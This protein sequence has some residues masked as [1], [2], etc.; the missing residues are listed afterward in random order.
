MPQQ[1]TGGVAP[2]AA[3]VEISGVDGNEGTLGRRGVSSCSQRSADRRGLDPSPL[4]QPRSSSATSR[5]KSMLGR[6]RRWRGQPCARLPRRCSCST[7][8]PARWRG[9]EPCEGLRCCCLP[10]S[11]SLLP[12]STESFRWDCLP[13]MDVNGM[14]TFGTVP[15]G[16][17]R[18]NAV[19]GQRAALLQ[20]YVGY[21][22]RVA[23]GQA[24]MLG[25]GEAE[26]TQEVRRRLT[27]AAETLG[28]PE[29]LER[30][31][32]ASGMTWRSLA[33]RLGVSP[34]RLREWRRG[35]VPA[36]THLFFL[37][38][39]GLVRREG[40]PRSGQPCPCAVRSSE[41]GAGRRNRRTA[42]NAP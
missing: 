32:T 4:R 39:L 15:I 9:L 7:A 41:T 36:S 22:Q 24:G 11:A 38:A 29:R 25:P 6:R 2:H 26:T 27:A 1:A 16:E 5:P 35:I 21:I 34:C 14:P 37:L 28:F 31:K 30:F 42:R 23:P 19:T 20:E 13:S 40:R 10:Q 33:R 18:T 3:V 12:T 17:A 8:V